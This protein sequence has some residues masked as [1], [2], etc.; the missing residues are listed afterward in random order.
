MMTTQLTKS[1]FNKAVSKGRK[2]WFPYIQEPT[3]Y[4]EERILCAM[5]GR[6]MLL[7]E[8]GGEEGFS[9]VLRLVLKQ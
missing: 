8:G 9:L 3:E 7:R 2:E 1:H 4:R 5:L 6:S